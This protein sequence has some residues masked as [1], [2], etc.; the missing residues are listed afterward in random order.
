MPSELQARLQL[1][2][3]RV[4]PTGNVTATGIRNQLG[5]PA[6]ERLQLLV[7][8]AV[9]NSWDAWLGDRTVP[10]FGVDLAPLERIQMKVLQKNVFSELPIG[11]DGAANLGE[12]LGSPRETVGLIIYDRG[13]TGMGGPTRADAKSSADEPR[14]FVDFFRNVGQPPDR[15]LGGGTYGYGK[16]ALYLFSRVSTILVYT[17][18][19]FDGLTPSRLMGACL[20][21]PFHVERG[22]DSGYYTGRHWWGRRADDGVVDPLE[23]K[24]ADELARWLGFPEFRRGETGTSILII[25]PEVEGSSIPQVL[26]TVRDT[27]LWYFWPKMLGRDNGLPQMRFSLNQAGVPVPI[28]APEDFPPLEGFVSAM[29]NLK[30]ANGGNGSLGVKELHCQR[31][32]KLLGSVS[33]ERFRHKPRL[34][35]QPNEN[36]GRP[37]LPEQCHHVALMR[38]AELV[39]RYLEGPP[40]P[41]SN[42]E[43]AGVFVADSAVDGVFAAAEPPSHDD[44]IPDSVE[45]S[46][47]RS[48]VRVALRRISEAMEEFVGV[49]GGS[50]VPGGAFA[51]AAFAEGMAA[52]L[53][54]EPGPGGSVQPNPP[55][56]R[57]RR[58]RQPR[59]RASVRV[60]GEGRLF[61]EGSRSVLEIAFVVNHAER[62]NGTR[63]TASA[64]VAVLEGE[65]EREPPKG[66]DQPVVLG[67]GLGDGSSAGPTGPDVL[68]PKEVTGPCRV[69]IG[70]PRDC[71]ISVNLTAEVG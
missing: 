48:I 9:Q 17:R 2:S 39:V 35:A 16:A 46:A 41:G 18:C 34:C 58:G 6:L 31:P 26:E 11:G 7:R 29:R 55:L 54:G 21:D 40:L 5:R 24:A 43:Y 56:Q 15:P 53:P 12:F 42:L 10:L 70:I 33:F 67:W 20:G 68:V 36:G 64:T 22:P 52:L 3:E 1:Q 71:A 13:T 63:V 59:P 61:E 23:G 44:W 62:S 57:R 30:R 4:A 8:E 66:A 69:R 65:S 60:E 19:H 51:V 28:P 32:R 25:D 37:L 49:E 38:Q 27:L 14:D 50:A 45:P 47:N